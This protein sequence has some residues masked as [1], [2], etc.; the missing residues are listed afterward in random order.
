MSTTFTPA[1]WLNNGPPAISKAN[2]DRLEAGIEAAHKGATS[3]H[4]SRERVFNTDTYGSGAAPGLAVN[5]ATAFATAIAD[6]P[7]GGK[8]IVPPGS[9]AVNSLMT[10][11][12][13]KDITIELDDA[14]FVFG[15]ATS[16]MLLQSTFGT[17]YPVSEVYS[18]YTTDGA[19]GHT[20]GTSGEQMW[21]IRLL[22]ATTV[23]WKKGQLVKL[24][25]DDVISDTGTAANKSSQSFTVIGVSGNYVYLA[26]YPLYTFATN[27]RVA[28]WPTDQHTLI[29][30]EYR[31]ADSVL[32]G[33]TMG[34][35][36]VQTRYSAYSLIKDAV[37]TASA[38]PAFQ[39]HRCYGAELRNIRVDYAQDSPST[40]FGYAVND[41]SE[42]TVVDSMRAYRVRHGYTTGSG[43]PANGSAI[44]EY[45]RPYG[46]IVKDARVY[47]SSQTALDTHE[48]GAC[49][50]FLNPVVE[51]CYSGIAPRGPDCKIIGG[52]ITGP[53]KSDCILF[54]TYHS[55]RP[56]NG[57]VDGIF[58][59]GVQSTPFRLNDL[60]ADTRIGLTIANATIVNRDTSKAVCAASYG[61]LRY[62][63]DGILLP[64][65]GTITK[66]ESNGGTVAAST[67]FN[68]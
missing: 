19:W 16:A 20:G 27:V 36:L 57:Y 65:G 31:H 43:G 22:L 9:Y 62:R 7:A 21:V 8:L 42:Y 54:W 56:T 23:S 47:G 44:R 6:T 25:S 15:T 29:G 2:L 24:V 64:Q 53:I 4:A 46:A 34:Y 49:V 17:A 60:V 33:S 58:I 55:S 3:F 11:I 51:N 35:A 18:F 63:P 5:I 52:R 13:N 30:G 32:A 37:V 48:D 61:R 40:F 41:A 28:A 67:V 12:P 14:E 66:L 38:G 39:P 59:D 26:G 50:T 1:T 45:I 10:L 68:L